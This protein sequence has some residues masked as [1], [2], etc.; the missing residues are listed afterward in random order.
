MKNLTF[1]ESFGEKEKFCHNLW[2]TPE[3]QAAQSEPGHF[4]NQITQRWLKKPIIYAEMTD[5]RLEH[6]HFYSWFNILMKR[7]YLNPYIQDLYYLHEITHLSLMEYEK[8]K[9]FKEWQAAM[10]ENEMIA[11][12]TSEVE[13][14]Q[15]LNIR[16]KTFKFPIWYD[17]LSIHERSAKDVIRKKRIEAMD[18]PKN[19]VE[20]QISLYREGNKI[21]TQLWQNHYLEVEANVN[22]YLNSLDQ[23]QFRTWLSQKS[24]N[25]IPYYHQALKF[26]EFYHQHLNQGKL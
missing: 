25:H 16:D 21:W 13:I 1:L 26:S 12:L 19:K 20:K 22:R 7:N 6:S 14:Y 24:V 8:N 23:T 3:F 18:D 5:E 9:S 10:I 11:S 15:V 2:V 4:L 17:Q